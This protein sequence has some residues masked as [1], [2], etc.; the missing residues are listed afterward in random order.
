MLTS[1]ISMV[2]IG[3]D[4]Q[5]RSLTRA[6]L[7]SSGKVHVVAE[8]SDFSRA[9]EL[10][11]QFR[12]HSAL[13]ILNG[14][15]EQPLELIQHIRRQFPST[16]VVC[17]GTDIPSSVV[18]KSF[19]C[20]ATEFLCQPLKPEEIEQVLAKIR[21]LQGEDELENQVGQVIA[22]YSSRGGTGVTTLSVNLATAIHQLAR[23][24]AVL[25]DLNLQY[26][27]VPLFFGLDP[28]Y[29][30]ADVVRNQDRLDAQLLKSFLLRASDKLYCLPAPLR[31]EEAD[32]VQPGHVQRII[33]MLRTQFRYV[34]VDCQHVLDANTVTALDLADVVLVVSL[35]DVPSIYCTKRVLE[36]FRKM[37]FT[38]EKVKVVVNRYDKRD[39]VPLEKVQE[40]F[41]TK[42]ETVLSEDHRAVLASINM[43]NP[44]IVSQPKSAL[45]KQFTD[46][47]GQL[48]GRVE[49]TAQNGKRSR[50][51][52]LFS[53]LLGG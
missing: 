39:G 18:V 27:A 12:P 48:A 7:L 4:P 34:I 41:G 16:A 30:I 53:G 13:V 42:I 52:N 40:V 23:E 29:T 17:T 14:D 28:E 10:I 31:V 3:K 22:I 43:G 19:R 38:D 26:G 50:L 49:V 32:D 35:M 1:P 47:A 2:I 45:V 44:L 21:A 20:G 36:V 25:V 37:G 46:L 11:D 51:S 24:G 8:S 9:T 15:N 33:S 6:Q 5:E